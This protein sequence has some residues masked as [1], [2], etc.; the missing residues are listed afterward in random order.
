[1]KEQTMPQVALI[2]GAAKRIGR[3]IALDMATGGWSIA[4]HYHTSPGAAEETRDAIRRAGARAEMVRADLADSSALDGLI[5][6]ARAAL[7]PVGCLINNASIFEDDELA[8]MSAESW[9]RHMAINLRA[10][11][12]LTRHFAARLEA[13]AKG[14]VINIIDQRVRKLTPNFFSYTISKSALWTATRTLAQ[15]LAPRIRVNAVAP[16]PTLPNIRQ[17]QTDFARQVAATLLGRGPE[18]EEIAAAVR[19]ILDAP[20]L[21]GQMIALDGGQHLVWQTADVVGVSE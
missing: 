15:A 14:A 2:S 17:K 21:T 10:P 3:A 19:F 18:P 13:P 4:V 6:D 9:E 7:G 12:F 8:T 1:M 16:G 20:A 5:D 11:V